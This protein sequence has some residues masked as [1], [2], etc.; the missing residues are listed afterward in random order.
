MDKYSNIIEK[1]F[2]IE[3]VQNLY[4]DPDLS[5]LNLTIQAKNLI[6][7]ITILK[8][9]KALKFNS[10]L[11]ITAI[12]NLESE[13]IRFEVVYSLISIKLNLRLFIFI[14]IN[15]ED[16]ENEGIHTIIP[17]FEGANWYERE[18]WDMYGIKFKNHPN[19][20]R[21]LTDYEFEGH[22]LRKDFPLSGYVE[23]HYDDKEEKVVYE[24][25]KLE[26]EYRHFDF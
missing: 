11:D 19:L 16:A 24:P 10:L 6:K 12:D 1:I 21:I 15:Q 7:T 5:A 9:D 26:Q 14:K 2:K 4:Y 3:E 23:V 20:H 8:E 25:L 22:P 17:I 13:D 18:V